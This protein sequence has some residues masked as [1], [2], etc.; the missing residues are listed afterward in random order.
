[1]TIRRLW[2]STW[3]A[4][5]PMPGA[6]YIVSSMSSIKVPRRGIELGDRLCAG[7]QPGIGV[8]EDAS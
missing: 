2:T 1:M 4:A 7:S 8:F 6:A 3:V 5:R